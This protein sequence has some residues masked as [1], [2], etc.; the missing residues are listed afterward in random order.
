MERYGLGTGK[1]IMTLGRLAAAERYKGFDE[2]IELLPRLAKE[3]PGITYLVCGDGPD[4]RR[5]MARARLFR[6]EVFDLAAAP[7]GRPGSGDSDASN[8]RVVFTG[9]VAESEKADHYRLADLYVMPSSGEGFGIVYLEALACEIPVI[10]SKADGSREALRDGELG[11][12]VDP[13]DPEEIYHAIRRA[14]LGLPGAPAT[15]RRED[16]EYF[17]QECFE[18]RAHEIINAIVPTR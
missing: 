1:T 7:L 9:R 10:G 14:L 3:F 5:L 18:H 12:L 11:I 8:A 6:C 15:A 4:R 16:L 13:R 2:I 17:S